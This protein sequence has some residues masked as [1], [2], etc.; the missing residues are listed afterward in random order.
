[1][2]ACMSGICKLFPKLAGGRA[3]TGAA[4]RPRDS[5]SKPHPA[6]KVSRPDRAQRLLTRP[7]NDASTWEKQGVETCMILPFNAESGRGLTRKPSF[8][9]TPEFSVKTWEPKL[10]L[11]GHNFRSEISR[12]GGHTYGGWPNWAK[13]VRIRGRAWV[14]LEVTCV[15]RLVSSSGRRR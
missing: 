14:G 8:V 7:M 4:F 13:P 1:M 12:R 15:E 2:G 11:V 10:V 9:E 3:G 5:P 6:K